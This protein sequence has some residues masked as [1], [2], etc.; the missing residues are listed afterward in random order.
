MNISIIVFI[1]LIVVAIV[2]F[3]KN[4]RRIIRNIKLGKDLDR[5]DRKKERLSL[6]ARVAIGQSKM[7]TRP[8]VSILHF[9]VYAGFI[10]INIEVLEIVLDGLFG[11]HRL[12][13]PLGSFYTVLIST[14]EVLA[15]LV[16]V[17]CVIFLIRRNIIR[18]KRFLSPEMGGWPKTDANLILITEVL[19]MSAFILMNA[20]DAQ[21]QLLGAEHYT[22]VG[23]FPISGLL[24]GL[25]ATVSEGSLVVIER[26]LWWFHIAGI[27][28]FLNYLPYSKH[29]HILLA[30]PNV[31]Y[32]KLTPA[33]QL[34]N[35]AAVKKEVELMFDPN[36]DPYAAPP[37]PVGEPER[38]GAKDVQDLSWKQ[39]MDSYTCTECGRCTDAC[40]AN[41][42]GKALS[43][44]KILMDTR[45][46]LEEV[47]KG[48][49]KN[50]KDYDDGKSLLRDYISEEELLACTS[51]NACTDACPVNID[52]LAI[53][54]DLRQYLI[55]EE[56]KAPAEWT[57]IFTNIE[58]NGAP[59]QFAQADRLKWKDEE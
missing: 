19:L 45:D 48:I 31:F 39:L 21:L 43:P 54:I 4:V 52:P 33:G 15:L 56:S 51:C 17:S 20:V 16:L 50:G 28:T 3:A 35:M 7:N 38:F 27:F 12:F 24:A 46:R 32:S 1:V 22:K 58:N 11:T 25:F 5:K 6:M 36:V 26:G 53:I 40:P 10:I 59:W 23:S 8:I 49:D 30:F 2:L 42:T 14:F 18:I 29:F 9:V 34:P 41:I 37:E 13:A 44:R 55:M 57:G 47:G